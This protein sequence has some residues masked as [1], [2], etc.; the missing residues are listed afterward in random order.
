MMQPQAGN[1]SFQ[2]Q[3]QQQIP[4]DIVGS[5][6]FGRY[7]KISVEETFNMMI[8]DDAM[9]PFAG[10]KMKVNIVNNADARELYTSTK[11]NHMIT[12]I[13][14]GV[15]TIS[16]NLAIAKIATLNTSTGNV[17]IAENLAGQIGIA[18]GL[19]IY[20]FN[21][22]SNTFTVPTI[23]FLPVY[24]AYQDT[25]FIAADGRTNNWR[26]SDNDD[27]TS[28]PSS[29]SSVGELQTK[30]TTTVATVPLDRQLF[31]MG[32]TVTEPWFDVGSQLFPYQRSNYY[33]IDY[34]T[35]SSTS[36]AAAFG[37]MVWLASNEKGGVAL[38]YSQG[39]QPVQISTDGIDFKLGQLSHPE[40]SFG[41]L[42]KIDGHIFYQI[43]FK[44]D[45]LT[46]V[47]DF[48][49]GKFFTLTDHALN[50]HIA[51][52]VAFFNSKYYFVSFIDGALYQ[53]G[54]EF[55]DYDGELI[56]R[57]RKTKNLRLQ[58][59]DNF[60][61]NN[62]VLTI[63]QGMDRPLQRID[64]NISKDGGVSFGNVVS[65]RLHRLGA[66]PNRF[67]FYSL[68][69]ANDL[70][71]QFWFWGLGRFVVIGGLASIYQ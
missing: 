40:D 16:P 63:E 41:F 24:I 1:R 10:Y 35:I 14:N 32:K 52:R 70:V 2:Y 61:V 57:I 49:T 45:N 56:P 8:S 29:S 31:I 58:N 9:V 21:Y 11:Y 26:L 59:S 15:Y 28:W 48:N 62:I 3:N 25:Y 43:T 4:L 22:I 38:M 36:I 64:L 12:V 55:T 33:S 20:I 47:Y 6:A 18:D 68:G 27:G 7:P 37:K 17:F 23:D 67:N 50:H 66:R 42:F 69:A 60:V 71:A 34:G 30:T 19:N 54:S 39:Q 13:G 5:T 53:M 46:Y 51:K 65:Q 44:A